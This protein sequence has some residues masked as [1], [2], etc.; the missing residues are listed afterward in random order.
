MVRFLRGAR[1][2]SGEP[3]WWDSPPATDFRFYLVVPQ[4]PSG[5]VGVDTIL[6]CV[7]QG[8]VQSPL[9]IPWIA[10]ESRW[11]YNLADCESPIATRDWTVNE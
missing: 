2:V 3:G 1:L 8:L 9:L 6:H 4:R 11:T 7:P 5:Q 10:K